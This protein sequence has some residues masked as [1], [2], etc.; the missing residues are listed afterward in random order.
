[1]IDWMKK[2]KGDLTY[3]DFLIAPFWSLFNMT[4]ALAYTPVI[5]VILVWDCICASVRKIRS[6]N[7]L[8][9][10]LGEME[11]IMSKWLYSY[12]NNPENRISFAGGEIEWEVQQV[13]SCGLDKAQTRALYEAMKEYYDKEEDHE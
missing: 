7:Y 9:D 11:V 12:L 5:L 10:I 6:D 3:K 4:V 2:S 13:R 1:M 8:K